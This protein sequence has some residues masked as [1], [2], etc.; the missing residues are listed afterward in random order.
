MERKYRNHTG[1]PENRRLYSIWKNMKRRCFD[2]RCERYKDYG[3]RGITMCEEWASDF[4][5]FADWAH[6]KEY[7]EGLTIERIN[8][9]GNYEPRNCKWITRREQAYNT[10]QNRL[11]TYHGETK[12]LIVWCNELNLPY[13]ATHNRI[14]S[15]WDVERAFTEPLF[16]QSKSWAK[17]CKAHGINPSTA[18]DRM[19]KLGWTEEQALN[20]PTKGRGTKATDLDPFRYGY[21]ECEYCKKQFLKRTVGMR[22]CSGECRETAKKLRRKAV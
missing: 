17:K 8:N 2:E 20:T 16:D 15:G 21:V 7:E 12:P 14:E 19:I 3:G 5:A 4:D 9:D 18:R 11:V 22:F 13:D 6:A 10:R 1:I